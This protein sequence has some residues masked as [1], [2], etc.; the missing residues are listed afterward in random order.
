MREEVSDL[1]FGLWRLF[2]NSRLVGLAFLAA[3]AF[4]PMVGVDRRIAWFIVIIGIPINLAEM[5]ILRRTRMVPWFTPALDA[6]LLAVALSIDPMVAPVAGLI[7]MASNSQAALVGWKPTLLSGLIGLPFVTLA[8]A[9]YSPSNAAVLMVAY[10]ITSAST[11]MFVSIMA[12]SERNERRQRDQLLHGIDAIVWQASPYPFVQAEFRGR[13]GDIIGESEEVL[14]APGAWLSRLPVSDRVRITSLSKSAID[15]GADHELSYRIITSSGEIKHMRDRIRVE[16]DESGAPIRARGVAVDITDQVHVGETNRNLGEL[17]ERVPVGLVVAQHDEVSNEFTVVTVNPAYERL[18]GRNAVELLSAP[19]T[20]PI[21][22]PVRLELQDLMRS[23]AQTGIGARIDEA[24]DLVAGG[25]RTLSLESFQISSGLIGLSITDVS[26]TVNAAK[27]IRHRAL[28]DGLT[29]LP[30]R[31]LFEDRL[32]H[33]RDASRRSNRTISLLVI[34]L[35]QFKDVNDTFGHAHGDHL[36]VEVSRR[37][38]TT[39]RSCDTVAR[40]GGDEFAVLLS[41]DVTR[42]S[43]IATAERI[44]S[45]FDEP[46]DLAGMA[47][48]CGASIGVAFHPED[49]GDSMSLQQR[50]DAAMYQAKQTGGG[51]RIYDHHQGADHDDRL[52][53][54]GELGR[55]IDN[56]QLLV[57]YQPLINLHTG[58]VDRVEALVRWNHPLRGLIQ[59]SRF[60]DVAEVSGIIRPLT[61]FVMRRA[62]NDV[63]DFRRAG[64]DIGLAINISVRNLYEPSFVNAVRETLAA[65]HLPGDTVTLEI[66]ETQVMD[67]PIL[68][69]DVLGR[70]GAIGVSGSVDDFGTGHSSLSN[71]QSLPVSEVKI[72]KSF[73]LGMA[74][75]D[76]ASAT[77]VKS[78]VAL[79]HNLG[80]DVAAEGIESGEMLDRVKALGCDRAQ[81]FHLAHPMSRANLS[82]F[83]DSYR[84]P[85]SS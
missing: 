13:T 46:V 33:A 41:E 37:L 70:L 45:T 8:M 15:A 79:G 23:T 11:T 42:S 51:V 65:A 82:T 2:L 57:Y 80:L 58:R 12:D 20:E 71:L 22:G 14:S 73:V 35:D 47:V 54:V 62:I 27:T 29:N 25:T 76:P 72:D 34:D 83:L 69:D 61:K 50:A 53:I 49:S 81:G 39:V 74:A 5:A 19:V 84:V 26:D 52:G 78:I 3:A 85:A 48:R 63:S 7:L 30:N 16:L 18:I 6:I 32:A 55:A 77:I 68:A 75:G 38:T 28:H 40:L 43:A 9:R 1:E 44:L 67:D 4:V 10:V 66:T 24:P 59:P 64:H 60:I 31:A 17:I 21:D 36:L 56:E